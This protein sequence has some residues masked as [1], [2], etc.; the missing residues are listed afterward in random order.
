MNFRFLDAGFRTN[1]YVTLRS[2]INGKANI[3]STA[4]TEYGKSMEAVALQQYSEK[5]FKNHEK[6]KITK[7]ALIRSGKY[8]FIAA[9][10]DGLVTC[11]TV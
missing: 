5:Y 9:S 8:P 6:A 7:L 10:P 11:V 4:A 2:G 3:I 1:R